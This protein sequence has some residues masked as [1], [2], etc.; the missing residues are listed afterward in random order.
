MRCRTYLAYDRQT[1]IGPAQGNEIVPMID[2]MPFLRVF[3]MM[4]TRLLA[5]PEALAVAGLAT[6]RV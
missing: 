2:I 3:F 5:G 6:N 1:G 4:M